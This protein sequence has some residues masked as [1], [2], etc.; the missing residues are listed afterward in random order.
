MTRTVHTTSFKIKDNKLA[1]KMGY[2]C[3]HLADDLLGLLLR[4]LEGGGASVRG[5]GAAAGADP[6]RVHL[7]RLRRAGC[8][9]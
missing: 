7:H 8:G 9:K 6:R 2:P 1:N 5:A 3:P 4:A